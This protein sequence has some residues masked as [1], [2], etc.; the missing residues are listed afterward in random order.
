MP[1]FSIIIPVLN[2]AKFLEK[3]LRSVLNQ[4]GMNFE[5]IVVD[6]GSTDGSV[7]I[8]RR[9]EDRIAWWCSEKDAGQSA[10]INKGFGHATGKYLFWLNADDLLLPDTLHKAQKYLSENPTCEWLAGNLIY[11]D[12]GDRVLW[13]ARDGGWHDWLYENA[14][15][16][17]YGPSSIFIKELFDRVGGLDESLHYVMDTDLWLRFKKAGAR[18]HRLQHYF[19][20]FRV[21]D[22]S[23]TSADL[24]GAATPKMVDERARM[25]LRNNFRVTKLGLLKQRMWRVCNGAY[26]KAAVDTIRWKK[27]RV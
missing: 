12:Q 23:K 10:A 18:F 9:Y 4:T 15:V 22:D 11:I 7:E 26:F 25:Y 2:H 3:A 5:V 27:R 8:I 13:C 14:P 1:V 19:W 17:V 20:A 6:G 24:K 16:R 21:H